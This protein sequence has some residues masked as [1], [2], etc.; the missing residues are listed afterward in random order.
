MV[1]RAKYAMTARGV[2]A[3]HVG[4]RHGHNILAQKAADPA[5]RTNKG[6][7]LVTPALRAVVGPL[8]AGDGLLA[9]SG[10]NRRSRCGGNVLLGEHIL[11]TV[12]VLATDQ[13]LG[14]H[15][16]LAGKA[17]GGLGG[18]TVSV[19][20]DVGRGAALDLVDLVGRSGNVSNERSQAARAR[21]HTDLAVGQTGLVETLWQSWSQAA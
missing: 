4:K 10:Q 2:A 3:R 14:S 7:M 9:Q 13:V 11:A 15:T 18:V 6:R 20:R 19:E 16:A 5:D 1:A 21:D 8:Q 12:S 17:L